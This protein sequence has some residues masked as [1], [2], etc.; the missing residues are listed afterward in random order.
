MGLESQIDSWLE[1]RPHV[2]RKE[3]P[4]MGTHTRAEQETCKWDSAFR[5]WRW[6]QDNLFPLFT[7]GPN[8]GV[9]VS[10]QDD[11][12]SGLVCLLSGPADQLGCQLRLNMRS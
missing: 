1:A 12:S 5:V 2:M 10:T 3:L 7:N 8:R 11:C 9:E 4:W 6:K